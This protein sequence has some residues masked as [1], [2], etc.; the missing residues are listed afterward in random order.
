M[1]YRIAMF[2]KK[3]NFNSSSSSSSSS[4]STRSSKKDKKSRIQIS[5]PSNFE[6]R[7]HTGYDEKSGGYVGLPPQWA[8]IVTTSSKT[9]NRP[10]PLVDPSLI[11]PTEVSEM[12]VRIRVIH[13]YPRK[14]RACPTGYFCCHICD[15]VHRKGS[16][17]K[18]HVDCLEHK[19]TKCLLP[20]SDKRA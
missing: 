17:Q 9:S 7:V 11:T 14:R 2:S 20:A 6:H 12:K 3:N 13:L 10:A 19:P 1:S 15:A 16:L 5:G 18:L 4:S 8:N